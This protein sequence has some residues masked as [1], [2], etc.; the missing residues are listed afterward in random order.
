MLSTVSKNSILLAVYSL[1]VSHPASA[2]QITPEMAQSVQMAAPTQMAAPSQVVH[3]EF[4]PAQMRPGVRYTTGYTQTRGWETNLVKGDANLGHWNWSPMVSYNQSSPSKPTGRQ[5]GPA[6]AA[7]VPTVSH[8]VKMRHA[9]L[10]LSE[11]Q[12][13]EMKNT[14]ACNARLANEKV[15]ARLRTGP[16]AGAG[17]DL[18]GKLMNPPMLSYGSDYGHTSAFASGSVAKAD[19]YAVIRSH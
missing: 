9:P 14:Q 2:Q 12:I 15:N 18:S 7:N 3:R 11:L 13:S 4:A 5:V 6:L 19:V 10:P 8:Y 1:I 16:G 17:T